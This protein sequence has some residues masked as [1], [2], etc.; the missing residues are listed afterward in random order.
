MLFYD[1][2]KSI[3]N[4][5]NNNL[6]SKIFIFFIKATNFVHNM[7]EMKFFGSNFYFIV[8][9]KISGNYQI[10]KV[11]QFL[12]YSCLKVHSIRNRHSSNIIN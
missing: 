7:L 12:L 11:T 3:N 10:K 1:A 4:N 8:I 6:Y 5:N 2:S 9:D